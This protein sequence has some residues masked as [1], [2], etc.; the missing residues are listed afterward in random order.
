MNFVQLQTLTSTW[1]D[2]LN[3]GYFTLPQIKVW[4]NN[5]QIEAQKELISSG[6]TWYLK[7][8]QTT[9][10][11]GQADY[12]L[13]QDF[14]ILNR[15][16]V[17]SSGT[18]LSENS[19]ALQNLTLNQKDFFQSGAGLPQAYLMKKNRIVLMP[20][21][22]NTYILRMYYSPM[23][24]DMVNDTDAPDVPAQYQEY[25]AILATLDGM[26]RDGRD[27]TMVMAKKAYYQ[28]MMT[29][30]MNERNKDSPRS[31]VETGSGMGSYYY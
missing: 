15:L 18:G 12:V 5:A 21:P 24:A 25:L 20:P 11:Y 26:M 13:P 31:I 16:E 22:D 6:N 28:A 29:T 14:R 17:I 2:D 27:T 4:L 10:V 8:I 1:L 7:P 30:D 19:N 9:C 23:V 3:N